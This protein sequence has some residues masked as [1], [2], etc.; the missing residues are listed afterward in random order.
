M[1]GASRAGGRSI[2]ATRAA[3]GI[4]TGVQTR[5]PQRFVFA[6]TALARG[7]T[8]TVMSS[9][10]PRLERHGSVVVISHGPD[11]ARLDRP[12]IRVGGRFGGPM[13]FPAIWIYAAR[14]AWACARAARG[15]GSVLL[16]QD[17]LAT[18]AAAGLAGRLTRTPVVV[19][20]HGSAIA[21]RSDYYWRERV[22]MRRLRDRLTKPLLRVSALL[23]HRACLRL[24]DGA[25]LAGDESA[26]AYRAAGFPAARMR[27]YHFPVDMERFRPAHPG[28][29]AEARTA[30]GLPP[31]GVI[32]ASVSRLA[33]EKGLDVLIEAVA[34][35]APASRP[36]VAFGGDGPLRAALEARVQRA[37]LEA[38]FLGQLDADGVATLL[39]AADIFVYAG[40]Q[41]AN[42]PYAVLEAMA[43]GLAVVASTEP[44][45]HADMLADG[46][47]AAVPRDD[48]VEHG[49]GAGALRG[50]QRGTRGRRRQGAKLRGGASLAGGPRRRAGRDRGLD[51]I[52][53]RKRAPMTRRLLPGLVGESAVYGI[54]GV[55]NQ[56]LNIILV[57][58]YARQLA[59]SGYGVVAVINATLSLASMVALLALPQAFFRS[60]LKE[61][62][63]ET[64][65][66]H[67]LAVTAALRLVASI[68][69]LGVF[70]LISVPVTLL[71]FGGD[72]GQLPLILLIA[73]IVFFDSLNSIP[74]SFLRAQ[75]RPGPYV[76]ITS[77]AR[78]WA[79]S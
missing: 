47:G 56:A 39:R 43:S 22:V 48:V 41:G 68:V 76:A 6:V 75:R 16:P 65:R 69:F 15:G 59:T 23:L 37:G 67:V 42:T 36:F 8:L 21:V 13:R 7:G 63:D 20:E 51:G 50:E 53:V 72:I 3:F 26:A 38:A 46:R 44:R 45:V 49:S 12:V 32:V 58:I 74:L 54:G 78:S 34:A 25:L 66:A 62:E 4:V 10:W 24:A 11:S 18:G 57:P 52:A 33:P 27:R 17:S 55:A 5:Q 2:S 77:R 71:V 79:A 29:V 61:S 9:L 60:Y 31:D 40:R 1:A 35:L 73:P 64:Q 30:L 14:M 19:M 28:E 70:A